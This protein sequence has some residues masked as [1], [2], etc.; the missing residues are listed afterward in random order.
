M[1]GG[2]APYCTQS[3]AQSA[4]IGARDGARAARIAMRAR[5]RSGKH[6]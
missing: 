3:L 1:V 6:Q 5:S 2:G 4:N